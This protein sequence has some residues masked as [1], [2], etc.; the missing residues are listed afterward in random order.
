M[1]D[2]LHYLELKN[3]YYEKFHTVTCRFLEM[4]NQDKWENL[5]L[6]VDNRER[7]LNI[8]RSFDY[9]IGIKMQESEVSQDSVQ[10][11]QSL[12]KNL[13]DQ[14][15]AWVQKIVSLDLEIA[16]KMEELKSE[17]IRELKKTLETN[18]QLNSFNGPKPKRV[19]KVAKDA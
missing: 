11:Y 12:V 9:K 17:T 7:I 19:P 13:F 4:A 2:V 3:Q 6:F 15:N 14:R 16:A 1:E 8:I 5:T 18:Q 10:K